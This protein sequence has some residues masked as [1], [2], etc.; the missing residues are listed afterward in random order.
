MHTWNSSIG[1]KA[2]FKTYSFSFLRYFQILNV[3]IIHKLRKSALFRQQFQTS[4]E[5][6]NTLSKNDENIMEGAPSKLK[7]WTNIPFAI[8]K[9]NCY[10]LGNV[11]AASRYENWGIQ[12]L[13][14]PK[15]V[16]SDLIESELVEQ[17]SGVKR[18]VCWDRCGG[19]KPRRVRKGE[20][21]FWGVGWVRLG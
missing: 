1:Y 6:R 10:C 18:E 15:L 4:S 14:E 5:V 17:G 11:S 3:I 9:Q 19:D 2:F 7:S 12:E 16:K 13:V 21:C 20:T 8:K